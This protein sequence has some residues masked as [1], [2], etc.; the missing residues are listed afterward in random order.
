MSIRPG[1]PESARVFVTYKKE[2][3]AMNRVVGKLLVSGALSLGAVTLHTLPA[4]ASGTIY[5]QATLFNNTN[6][7]FNITPS[8]SPGGGVW[9]PAP[10]VSV[11]KG[12]TISW[13]SASDGG[14]LSTSGTG[15][16]IYIPLDTWIASVEW[17]VPW[18][19]F[20]GLGGAATGTTGGT[21]TPN[22][23]YTVEGGAEGCSGDGPNTCVFAYEIRQH[24][25]SDCKLIT[26]SIGILDHA[27]VFLNQNS[28][29]T[30]APIGDW[31]NGS[32]KGQCSPGQAVNGVSSKLAAHGLLCEAGPPTVFLQNSSCR[33]VP[34]DPGNNP[35]PWSGADWDNGFYK[36]QCQSNE[37]VAGVAQSTGDAVDGI[38]C[39]PGEGLTQSACQLEVFEAQN[40]P[41]Y[42]APDWD[43][44]YYK[45]ECAAGKYVAGVS[46]V[47]AGYFAGV[48]HA[49]YCCSP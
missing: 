47:A 21:P 43:N 8:S 14:F 12:Q 5:A 18:S 20:N 15:G 27:A 1:D 41:D 30:G 11:D 44:G 46:A 9:D 16:T 26:Q 39:C 19:Y 3:V 33:S 2:G 38:L 42:R 35:S 48:P 24:G 25:M 7:P 22:S 40:S 36:A 45:G 29:Y 37:Y 17:S 13:G 49:I 32:Y 34:F 28:G 23:V 31:M 6:C 10:P 4:A